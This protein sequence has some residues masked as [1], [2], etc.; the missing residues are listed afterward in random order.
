VVLTNVGPPYSL[1]GFSM[2]NRLLNWI[3]QFISPNQGVVRVGRDYIAEVYQDEPE[4]VF[5]EDD[6]FEEKDEQ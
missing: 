1:L 3:L 5:D 6:S 2:V 4:M